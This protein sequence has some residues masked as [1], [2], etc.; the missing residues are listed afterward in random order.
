MYCR[1]C[2]CVN[3]VRME[4]TRCEEGVWVG[5]GVCLELWMGR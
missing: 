5:V 4:V 3:E 2:G 1:V